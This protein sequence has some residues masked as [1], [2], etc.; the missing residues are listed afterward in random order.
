MSL[1]SLQKVDFVG[2][3]LLLAASTLL[4]FALQE[5]GS[6]MYAWS[7][8]AIISTLVL[9]S[10]CWIAFFAWIAWLSLGNGISSMRAILPLHIVLSR[11][12]GPAIVLVNLFYAF[13]F[14]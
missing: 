3:L 7:S 10:V 1:P 13:K 4:V 5:A 11:P 9:S 8:S 14:C 6:T 12:T 2:A